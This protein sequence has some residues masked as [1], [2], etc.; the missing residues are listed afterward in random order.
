MAYVVAISLSINSTCN[1]NLFICRCQLSSNVYT[2]FTLVRNNKVP[3]AGWL[4]DSTTETAQYF[5]GRAFNSSPLSIVLESQTTFDS[6]QEESR[7]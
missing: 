2:G 1:A 7:I 6:N 5:N 3:Q 4:S